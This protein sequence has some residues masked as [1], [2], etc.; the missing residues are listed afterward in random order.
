MFITAAEER[1]PGDAACTI[2]GRGN[3]TVFFAHPGCRSQWCGA[4][5]EHGPTPG[6][7]AVP[8]KPGGR[9][10]LISAARG[11]PSAIA[12]GWG[13]LPT[14]PS[15]QVPWRGRAPDAAARWPGA[16]EDSP[17]GKNMRCTS[18]PFQHRT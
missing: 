13:P 14:R 7:R 8:S 16:S 9:R 11:R 4:R 2:G 6:G 18:P 1:D 3:I 5:R 10:G 12:A 17:A 15:R